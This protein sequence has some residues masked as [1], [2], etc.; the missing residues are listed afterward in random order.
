MNIHTLADHL[1]DINP[2]AYVEDTGMEL[3]R[4]CNLPRADVDRLIMNT[5][6]GYVRGGV[7]YGM[8]EHYV[9]L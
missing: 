6:I 9:T 5:G 8:E 3:V 1:A 7:M 4:L 2:L